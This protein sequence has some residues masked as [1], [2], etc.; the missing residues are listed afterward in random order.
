LDKLKKVDI[1]KNMTHIT[2]EKLKNGAT[3]LLI[4]THQAPVTS[5]NICLRVGSRKETD[6]EAGICHLIEHMLFKG[7]KKLAPGEVAKKIEAG[8]GDVNAYTSWDET[9]YYCTL[10]SRHT[11][12]GLDILSD[13]ALNSVIDP[14]E[15][16]REREVV[17]EEI[18]R[19]KDSPTRVLSEEIFGKAFQSHH[20]GRPIIGY[21]KTVRGFSRKKVLDFYHRWYIPKNMVVVVAGDFKTRDI[22]K[23]CEK[24]FGGLP[25]QPSPVEPCAAEKQQTKTRTLALTNPIKGSHMALAYHVPQLD[26]EDIPPLDILSHILGEGESCRLDMEVKDKKGLVNAAYSTVYSPQDPGLFY[27]SYSL[28]EKNIAPASREILDQ[29]RRLQDQKVDH[30]EMVRAKLNIKSDTI[31][32][33]ETV[34]GLARKHGYFENI[35]GRYDFDD[36]YYQAIDD[37]TPDDLLRVAQK[38][39]QIKNLT[40]GLIQP[41]TGRKKWKSSD[42]L[43][44]THPKKKA[45]TRLKKKPEV[46]HLKLKNGLRLIFRENPNVPT[47]SIRTAHLAG[48]RAETKRNNG[49]HTLL[50]HLWGKSTTHLNAPEMARQMELIAGSVEAYTGRNLTGMKADFLSEKTRDGVRLFLDALLNPRWD[51]TEIEREK[52]NQ[53]EALRR[54]HDAMASLAFKL[55]LQ[56][57]FP[58]HPYGLSLL[59]EAKNVR[60]FKAKDLQRQ[61]QKIL[62]PKHMVIAVVGD[63]DTQ[64]MKD[65]L[66]PSLEDLKR[67]EN[68]LG[69][70][71]MDPLPKKNIR[72]EKKLDKFQAHIVYGFRGV[73]FKD[74][75]RY[76]LDVLNNILAGQ[77]GRLFLELRDK[78]SLA[79]S[80]TS[81][82]QEGIEP[83]Y[84]GVYIGTEGSKVNT[85]I[86]GIERELKKILANKVSQAE[87]DRAQQ[88]M[89]GAYDI[90]L[91]RNSYVA[92]QLAFNEI[93]GQG[94][95]EWVDLPKKIKKVTKDQVF[96]IAHKI[97]K[98]NHRVLSVVRPKG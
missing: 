8:G 11:H 35:L 5:I 9:V 72:V 34:E 92:T 31:Y 16:D 75:D 39:L 7:T 46:S 80:V 81:L 50:S 14:T 24:I 59:G 73:R 28:P 65:L 44:L 56:K 26:H 52:F 76:A 36:H 84:F 21:D 10:S 13:A 23:R 90:E 37:T 47:I 19:G 22:M 18:L 95:N 57:L 60:S 2:R 66:V 12:R 54:E 6:A 38:Y 77:G 71:K 3:V 45:K 70:I 94:Q 63:F 98:M 62:N 96:S 27:L 43:S 15:L 61:F 4:E 79:Y 51:A 89:V 97:L 30:D 78:M 33:K 55:F 64:A 1:G 93:Y 68:G 48:I 53:L 87:M 42:L 88:Y 41:Q 85:A 83:G 25:K 17:I 49:I 86:A 69:P 32:E 82:S 74:P 67:K 40:L 29:I 58:R 91:Q 20:Y